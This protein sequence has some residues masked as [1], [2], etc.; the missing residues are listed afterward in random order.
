MH[1]TRK[2]LEFE[3][4]RYKRKVADQQNE[5]KKLKADIEGY[6]DSQEGL[7]AMMTAIVEQANGVTVSRDRINEI[8]ENNVHTIVD[9]DADAR[10]YTLRVLG[11]EAD[12]EGE[13]AC[14]QG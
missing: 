8:V 9:W 3:L 12:G 7:F 13:E 10:T 2:M 11:G 1:M 4:G 14:K 5:I 6:E